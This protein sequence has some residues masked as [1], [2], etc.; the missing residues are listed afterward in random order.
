VIGFR[1]GA[2]VNWRGLT[3][4]IC[5]TIPSVVLANSNNEQTITL[6]EKYYELSESEKKFADSIIN[7]HNKSQSIEELKNE[8]TVIG[9]FIIGN[10][11]VIEITEEE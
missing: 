3:F 4:V 9:E 8:L 7:T 2:A 10:G 6:D 1:K 5:I 11:D